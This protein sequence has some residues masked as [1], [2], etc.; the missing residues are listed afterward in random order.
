M[1]MTNLRHSLEKKY[2]SLCGQLTEVEAN[3]SRIHREQACLPELEE[4]I[5]ELKAL[6]SSAE[7]L[8][9]EAKSDWEPEQ[10]LAI[11]PWTHSLPV[12][13]GSCG[14][15]GME[16]LRKATAPMTTR[17]IAQDVLREMG[18]EEVSPDIM[19]RTIGAIEASLRKH[20]GKTVE[21]SGKYPAQWRSIVKADIQ[22]DI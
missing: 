19:K 7:M 10:T 5:T 14:R 13:F 20:R 2:A 3:I 12:P 11:R 21:S 18:C 9:K 8:L 15:R 1:G 4:R 6:I 22:F 16:V 17:Q